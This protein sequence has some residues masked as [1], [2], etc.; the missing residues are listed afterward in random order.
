MTARGARAAVLLLAAACAAPHRSEPPAAPATARFELI[1]LGRAQDGGLPHVG[2]ERPC[3]ADARRTG[4]VETPAC[5]GVH[6]RSTGALLLVEAT[7]GIERQLALL[8][9]LTGQRGT[10][11]RRPVDAVVLTHAHIGHY[12]GLAQFGRE[13]AGTRDLPV[14]ASPRMG[15]FLRDHGP[16]SQLV[17]LQQ[18]RLERLGPGESREVLPGLT[19]EAIAVPHRDELSD[20]LA[21]KLHG[22]QRT[23]LFVP[24]IDR[25]DAAREDF[26]PGLLERLLERLLDGVDVAYLDATFY[27][28]SELPDRD[29][30]E[31]PHPLIVDTMDR[32]QDRARRQPGALRFIHLNHTNPALNDPELAKRIAARGFRVAEVGERTAL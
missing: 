32:L 21:L 25:W 7:P 4:R 3:C 14:Y 19:V 24:D 29:P 12:L 10:R 16:W 31:I 28:G 8:H 2:C 15:A 17:A 18:I 5:L 1:V 30:R 9:E 22:P 6:D 13:V 20:T 26:E 23:A 27:D 11:G